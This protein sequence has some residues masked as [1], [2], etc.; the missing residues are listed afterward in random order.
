M[1]LEKCITLYNQHCTQKKMLNHSITLKVLKCSFVG[2]LP[3]PS[4]GPGNTRLLCVYNFPFSRMS[5]EWDKT[6]CNLN[7]FFF[8]L[9]ILHSQYIHIALS[10]STLF[11]STHWFFKKD[12]FISEIE[13]ESMSG[14]GKGRREFQVDSKWAWSLMGAGYHYHEMETWAE[15]EVQML[16][17][18]TTQ[19]LHSIH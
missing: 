9:S 16:T 14:K 15:T 6:G 1:N 18:C 13:R 7:S 5:Y 19:T 10:V 8:L 2:K 17:N 4:Q 11:L 12:L 3:S